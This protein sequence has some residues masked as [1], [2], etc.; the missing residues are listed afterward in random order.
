MPLIIC[1]PR[2]TETERKIIFD[3]KGCLCCCKLYLNHKSRDCPSDFPN[4]VN[5]KPLT[6]SVPNTSTLSGLQAP[7]D[8]CIASATAII[9]LIKPPDTI[10]P[11]TSVMGILRNPA[12]SMPVNE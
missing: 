10:H 6:E 9:A 5:Y 11:V 1:C 3:N 2:L 4:G 12:A 8:L 7:P